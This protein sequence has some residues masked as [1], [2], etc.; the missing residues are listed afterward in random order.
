[1]RTDVRN[2]NLNTP[3]NPPYS[4]SVFLANYYSGNQINNGMG[5]VCG[6]NGG[7]DRCVRNLGQETG[8]NETISKLGADLRIILK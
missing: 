3:V 5:R 1:M 2:S 7:G 4:A 8:G 6:T